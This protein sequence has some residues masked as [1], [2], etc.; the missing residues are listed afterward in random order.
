MLNLRHSFKP[1]LLF[2]HN[3]GVHCCRSQV[4][5]SSWRPSIEERASTMNRSSCNNQYYAKSKWLTVFLRTFGRERPPTAPNCLTL[6]VQLMNLAKASQKDSASSSTP[7]LR[8]AQ[9]KT[10]SR[11]MALRVS[12]WRYIL[13]LFK[14]AIIT[15]C[16]GNLRLEQQLC[17][18]SASTL[19]HRP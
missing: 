11:T 13:N 19:S 16:K 17:P 12:W 5:P 15:L 3:F 4:I 9:I 10:P 2:D 6:E 7:W 18:L 14:R 1:K 8:M